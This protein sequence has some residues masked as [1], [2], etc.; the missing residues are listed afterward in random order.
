MMMNAMNNKTRM[1][2]ILNK[3]YSSS[4]KKTVKTTIDGEITTRCSG[5]RLRKLNIASVYDVTALLS[6]Q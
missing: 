5:L 4:R 6:S 1:G 3:K 2:R